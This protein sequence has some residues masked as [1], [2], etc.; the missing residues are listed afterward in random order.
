MLADRERFSADMVVLDKL[1]PAQDVG[2][3]GTQIDQIDLE[4]S[5]V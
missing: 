2:P 4:A 1:C 3:G 5:Y